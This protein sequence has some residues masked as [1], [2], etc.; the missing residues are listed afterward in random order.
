MYIHACPI[1][2]Q[3][4]SFQTII[5]NLTRVNI[6]L[7]FTFLF[8]RWLD[9][10]G[11][12]RVAIHFAMPAAASQRL[13]AK[14]RLDCNTS[15]T[16]PQGSS[17]LSGNSSGSCHFSGPQTNYSTYANP[18]ELIPFPMCTVRT[19]LV[20]IAP[21][22]APRPDPFEIACAESLQNPT[23]SLLIGFRTR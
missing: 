8:H 13:F 17:R 2:S 1:D 18:F 6:Y 20:L 9:I 10:N 11:Y 22:R 21:L 14:E 4:V 5:Q 19:T 23:S 15:T 3:K 12:L 7:Y 16:L